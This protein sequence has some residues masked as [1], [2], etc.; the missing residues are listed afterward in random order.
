MLLRE[1]LHRKSK[2]AVQRAAQKKITNIFWCNELFQRKRARQEQGD[3]NPTRTNVEE[4]FS[5]LGA[6]SEEGRNFRIFRP[7]CL[8]MR[9]CWLRE[10]K[11]SVFNKSKI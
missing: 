8:S 3:K 9:C 1:F 5:L 11:S 2:V 10:G 6:R 4:I 7:S